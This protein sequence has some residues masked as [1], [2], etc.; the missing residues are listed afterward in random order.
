MT[1]LQCTLKAS[2]TA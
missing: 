1:K 2:W